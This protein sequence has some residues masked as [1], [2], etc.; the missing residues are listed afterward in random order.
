MLAFK[1]APVAKLSPPSIVAH[2]CAVLP[3]IPPIHARL[4][5]VIVHKQF[6]RITLGP[7]PRQETLLTDAAIRVQVR[8]MIAILGAVLGTVESVKGANA[9]VAHTHVVVQQTTALAV[10]FA[11]VASIPSKKSHH[12]CTRT[13]RGPKC[14]A[15]N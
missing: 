1:D 2:A 8:A 5:A 10:L 13:S 12:T 14:H 3:V 9:I 15:R 7:H 4:I 6:A 11:H